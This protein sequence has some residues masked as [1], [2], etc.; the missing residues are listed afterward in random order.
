VIKARF[1]KSP[2]LPTDIMGMLI[3]LAVCSRSIPFLVKMMHFRSI[4]IHFEDSVEVFVFP[5]DI[6]L[7]INVL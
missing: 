4:I 5:L 1:C 7:Y 3:V 2:Y 6:S